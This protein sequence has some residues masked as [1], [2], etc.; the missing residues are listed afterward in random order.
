M[1]VTLKRSLG[2]QR[3]SRRLGGE[4]VFRAIVAWLGS[5]AALVTGIPAA[6][7]TPA[8]LTDTQLRETPAQLVSID[9]GVVSLY[10][11]SGV[12]RQRDADEI[13]MLR[14]QSAP[15]STETN[16][17]PWVLTL[18]DG[19]HWVGVPAAPLGTADN[20][21]L[22]WTHATL[23]TIAVS[24]ET[25]QSI[26]RL[27][28]AKESKARRAWDNHAEPP[29]SDDF[30]KLRN[31]DTL[32]GFIAA[33]D[34]QGITLETDTG[35][36]P[37]TWDNL[38][39]VRLA[40]P[41]QNELTDADV[42]ALRDGSRVHLR[43]VRL[44]ETQ[45]EVTPT[46]LAETLGI[47][48]QSAVDEE[49]RRVLPIVDAESLAFAASGFRLIDL[50]T[51]EPNVISGESFG[52][53][54]PPKLTFNPNPSGAWQAWVHAPTTLRFDVPAG[55]TATRLAGR[56]T[57]DLPERVDPTARALADATLVVADDS[58]DVLTRP[59]QPGVAWPFR[60]PLDC[61]RFELRVEPGPNG[62]ALDRVRF[63]RLRL[64]IQREDD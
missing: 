26:E 18:T 62:P 55:F 7:I 52:L 41:S 10:D 30:V 40:N 5:I 13:V 56:A 24:L 6:A 37:L 63:D 20:E 46:L 17:D 23:G 47:P 22:R 28:D 31:C 2:W 57:L 39:A 19:Q 4:S 9:E 48:E 25:V 3:E 8:T 27:S 14:F 33:L 32:T 53:S 50:T 16:D 1:N 49:A 35:D 58:A 29:P 44:D 38:A 61:S 21:T 59:L 15:T 11:A 43:G 60:V 36:V 64:L 51:F 42:L 34:D 54:F 45:I 12:L